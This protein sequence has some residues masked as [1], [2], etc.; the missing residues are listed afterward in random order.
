MM[1]WPGPRPGGEPDWYSQCIVSL[2]GQVQ[3][4]HANVL[5]TLRSDPAW[6]DVFAFDEMRQEVMLLRPVPAHDQPRSKALAKPRPWSDV[7]DAA[8]QEWMQIAGLPHVGRDTVAT[9]ISQRARELPIHPVR[10]WLNNL[11]WDGVQRIEGGT[12]DDGEIIEPWMTVYLGVDNNPYHRAVGALIL[13]SAVARIFIPGCKV[14]HMVI[15]EGPQNSGKSTACEILCGEEHFSDNLHDVRSKDA[16]AHISGKWIIEIA[17]LDAMSRA[18]NT[19]MKAFLTRRIDKFRPAYG[20]HEVERP[21][22]CIFIGTTNKSD[23]LTDETGGRRY[24]PVKTYAI[25]L[26]ALRSDRDKLWAEALHLYKQGREWHITDPE[27]SKL[28]QQE[29]SE[30]YDEDVWEEKVGDYL[31]GMSEVTVSQI[32]QEA[33]KIEVSHKDRAGQNR[34]TKI[35]TRL[36]WLR[37]KRSADRRPWHC[38]SNELTE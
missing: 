18:E 30:R 2:R 11:K 13:I 22:Q 26:E 32:M 15:L 6:K 27:I 12:T 19:A 17:E 14:D 9:A 33:L 35:L 10:G 21:R 29:Q 28:A 20:R 16:M 4:N 38:P 7:D 1:R 3:S 31:K 34:V 37:G 25:E 23:Y 24:W 36:G 5:I 8:T